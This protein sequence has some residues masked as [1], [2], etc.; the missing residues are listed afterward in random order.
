M[1][2]AKLSE[3]DLAATVVAWLESAGWDVY[4]EVELAS[5]VRPD[6]VATH[7]PLVWCVECKTSLSFGV[8]RQAW[9]H[10]VH[11]RSVAVPLPRHSNDDR[12]FAERVCAAFGV[13]LLGAA[14][15]RIHQVVPPAL[16]RINDRY[17]RQVRDRLRPEHKEYA[18]AGSATGGHFTP[19]HAT[20]RT[21]RRF[22]SEH[23]GC[24]LRELMN[25]L[26]DGR[27]HY[28]STA[29]CRAHLPK[30]LE[31]LCP[32]CRVDREAEGGPRLFLR[33][34][35]DGMADV[36]RTATRSVAQNET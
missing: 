3:Q 13:G 11:L 16:L 1:T 17:A 7:G 26:T 28:S 22:V 34:N 29:S 36:S 27:G 9:R 8:I 12:Q 21:A 31:Q 20:V 32:W 19:F 2:R 6:I 23:P 35:S 33:P 25:H 18:P 24:T 5:G 30:A 14:H 15:G 10:A 4:Q